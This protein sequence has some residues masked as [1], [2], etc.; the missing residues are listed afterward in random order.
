MSCQERGHQIGQPL[1][2]QSGQLLRRALRE[3]GYNTE[4][5]FY[6][7]V[8]RCSG[9]NPNMKEIRKCR[10]YLLQELAE[11][12][13]SEC[14]GL[15]LLG[16]DAIKGFFNDGM[17]SLKDHRLRV[18]DW[19]TPRGPGGTPVPET[20]LP[21]GHSASETN[22]QG[23]G[24]TVPLVSCPI[25]A[26][27]HPASAL[28]GRNPENYSEILSDLENLTKQRD[29]VKPVRRIAT[30]GELSE[31]FA[32]EKTLAIDLEWSGAGNIRCV[33]LSDGNTNTVSNA[34]TAMEWLDEVVRRDKKG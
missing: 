30:Q 34:D 12:D 31:V 11:L 22:V 25:R 32:G 24:N 15:V 26:T 20:S 18:L 19:A 7:N 1:V 28:P 33:G 9:G 3:T 4:E 8:V 5:V 13:Y 27:F 23:K 6:T 16:T 14:K 2:G 21:E 17:L 29:P 10:S